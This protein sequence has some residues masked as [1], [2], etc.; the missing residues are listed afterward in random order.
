[1]V[2]EAK[3]KKIFMQFTE[4]REMIINDKDEGMGWNGEAK[5]L[6]YERRRADTQLLVDRIINTLIN[7]FAKHRYVW[8]RSSLLLIII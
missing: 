5:S 7:T 2:D 8:I 4:R 6:Y 1:M 3:G